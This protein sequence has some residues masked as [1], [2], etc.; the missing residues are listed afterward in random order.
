MLI[1]PEADGRFNSKAEFELFVGKAG[2]N[3]KVNTSHKAK[4][5]LV[6]AFA[7]IEPATPPAMSDKRLK[8]RLELM[9]GF[10][11]EVVKATR[12]V[13][14]DN[15]SKIKITSLIETCRTCEG[16]SL[17]GQPHPSPRLGKTPKFMMVFDSPDYKEG[18]AGKMLESDTGAYVKSALKD[19]GLS[20]NDGYFTSLV[21]APKVKGSKGLANEMINGCSDYL[22]KEI[23]ILKPPVII[24]MGSNAV[25]FFVP[26]IKGAPADY[27]G[28][29]IFNQELDAN[30]VL[31]INPSSLHFDGS[32]IIQLQKV[33]EVIS[34]IVAP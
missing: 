28:K 7:S 9:A 21:K 6:G 4:L 22:R 16:C 20:V 3:S 18:N 2:L 5:D 25:K 8:D 13:S 10:T 14:S 11:T 15:L 23:E 26:N 17:K 1:P 29:V 31:G 33:C 12:G 30:I 24:A 27:S 34:N 32:R 19:A